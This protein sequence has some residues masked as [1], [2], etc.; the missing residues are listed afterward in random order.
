MKNLTI[1]AISV[2]A[3]ALMPGCDSDSSG[4]S[5]SGG[6]GGTG[7]TG[8]VPRRPAPAGRS[9]WRS[10]HRTPPAL[11]GPVTG[12]EASA[13]WTGGRTRESQSRTLLF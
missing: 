12:K 13:W 11:G 5:D 8:G 9:A 4:T 2:F 1:I 3:L 6:T 10:T 7:G